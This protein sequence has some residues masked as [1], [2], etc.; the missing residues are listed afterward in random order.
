MEI[1]CG[2]CVECGSLRDAACPLFLSAGQAWGDLW[3]FQLPQSIFP[4]LAAQLEVFPLSH[5]P[6]LL[7]RKILEWDCPVW[8]TPVLVFTVAQ[9]LGSPCLWG[10][11]WG[12]VGGRTGRVVTPEGQCQ[13]SRLG[14]VSFPGMGCVA[15][16]ALSAWQRCCCSSLSQPSRHFPLPILQQLLPWLLISVLMEQPCSIKAKPRD[17]PEP[18]ASPSLAWAA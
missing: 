1:P 17:V 11:L 13:E 9:S 15:V 10:L 3:L 14:D 6:S 18:R 2:V 5:L 8:D 4:S 16:C 7:G 12:G